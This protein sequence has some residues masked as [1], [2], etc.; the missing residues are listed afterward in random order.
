MKIRKFLCAPLILMK[1]LFKIVIP[2]LL[3][4]VFLAVITAIGDVDYEIPVSPS[5][6]S[7]ISF[8]YE[9]LG[10]KKIIDSTS[11]ISLVFDSLNNTGFHK[12]YDR[13]PTGGQTF[14]LVFHLDTGDDWTC[15]YYQTNFDCG[16]F[17]DENIKVSVSNLDLKA[18]WHQL[19]CLE[20]SAFA[21]HEISPPEL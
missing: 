15:T 16:F 3:L 4:V 21:S 6:I 9:N 11:D 7:S 14:F 19:S 13:F 18:L 2:S 5:T 8:Y 17:A 20:Y 12:K 1:S 10:K